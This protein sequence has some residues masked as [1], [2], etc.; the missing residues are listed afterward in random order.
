M[1]YNLI[2]LNAMLSHHDTLA[3]FLIGSIAKCRRLSLLIERNQ[4]ELEHRRETGRKLIDQRSTPDLEKELRISL[5]EIRANLVQ[6][7]SSVEEITEQLVGFDPL[8]VMD[9]DVK[10]DVA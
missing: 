7:V 9:V 1:Q 3:D 10:A 4:Q 2:P 6:Y 8:K 5:T